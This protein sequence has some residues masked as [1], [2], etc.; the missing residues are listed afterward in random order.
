MNN[1]QAVVRVKDGILK[2]VGINSLIVFYNLAL[3][4][5]GTEK[6]Q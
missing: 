6:E 1:L 4:L 5:I 2:Q 3:W